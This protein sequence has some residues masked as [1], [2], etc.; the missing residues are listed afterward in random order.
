MRKQHCRKR[1]GAPCLRFISQKIMPT[2]RR[3]KLAC[4][5]PNAASL[6]FGSKDKHLSLKL[7]CF[8]LFNTISRLYGLNRQSVPGSS[9]SGYRGGTA[10][11]GS[12]SAGFSFRV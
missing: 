3:S 1:R 10:L 9:A 2:E 11:S 6:G 8:Y 7:A 5:C 4:F 12:V